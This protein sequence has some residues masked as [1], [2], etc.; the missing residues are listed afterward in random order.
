M[1]AGKQDATLAEVQDGEGI[2]AVKQREYGFAVFLV[3]MDQH[4]A[5][6]GQMEAVPTATEVC[7]KFAKVVDLPVEG[8]PNGAIFVRKGLT[9]VGNVHEG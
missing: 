6:A 3:E 4:F 1:V 9:A 8:S 7:G 2:H 5:V